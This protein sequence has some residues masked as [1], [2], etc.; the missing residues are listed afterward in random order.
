M[1]TNIDFKPATTSKRTSSAKM[2]VLDPC[3]M[4]A[5]H[6]EV[7]DL[8]SQL[9]K[10]DVLV[11]N[12]AATIP[13]SFNL[14]SI[15]GQ[16]EFRLISNLSVQMYDPTKWSAV[17]YLKG[18]WKA[19]TEEREIFNLVQSR[20]FRIDHDLVLDIRQVDEHYQIDFRGNASR[21]WQFL[22]E[23]GAPIQYSYHQNNLMLWDIQTIFASR[24]LALEAP[25]AAFHIDWQIIN[26]AREKGVSVAFISHAA[27]V[28]ATG[29]K[30]IDDQLPF[31]ERY[32]IPKET[33]DIIK[34]AKENG[35]RVIAVGTSAT[36]AL[37]DSH[38]KHGYLKHGEG[39]ANTKLHRGFKLE[40]VDGLISGLHEAGSSHLKLLEAF[41]DKKRLL[42]SYEDALKLGYQNHEYGDIEF[43]CAKCA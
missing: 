13:A 4:V 12:D 8:P 24:P 11:F 20:S 15:W 14:K 39:L 42:E 6:M 38:L 19:K 29:V 10:G 43:I 35:G 41:I 16:L 30:S 2:M 31:D 37:E 23:K 36:R 7:S 27:G 25:S 33:A 22:Y 9:S 3:H 40:V 34:K 26:N 5:N 18:S 28:S 17:I 32:S 21:I 1:N